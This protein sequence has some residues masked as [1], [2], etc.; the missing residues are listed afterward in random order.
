MPV[1]EAEAKWEGALSDGKGRMA[2][3]S[4]AF[5]GH[6]SFGSRFEEG[7]G[8][9]PE[10]LIGAAH[11]GCFSMQ[12]SGLLEKAGHTA[13]EISSTARVHLDRQDEGFAITTIDLQ[14]RASV[15]GVSGEEFQRVAEEAKKICPVSRALAGVEI[16]LDAELS[17]G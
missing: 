12:L 14:T 15:P 17:S 7:E 13:D 4:G 8:T 5:E 1:R 3:G 11:A 2:F 16:N 6:Y 10:E 9:N